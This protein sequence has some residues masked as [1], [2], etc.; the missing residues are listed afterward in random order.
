MIEQPGDDEIQEEDELPSLN[1]EGA[2]ELI[3]EAAAAH[4]A[5]KGGDAAESARVAELE[6]E[7]TASKDRLLRLQADYDNFRKRAVKQ[8]QESQDFG[9]EKFVKDLLSSVDNLE[10]ALEH[11]KSNEGAEI[12][13]GLLEGV[14][15]VYR[16]MLSVLQKHSVLVVDATGQPFNPALHEAMGQAP[17]ASVP[18]NTVIEVFQ[19]GYELK[20]HLLRPA[21]V[22]VSMAPP[23]QEDVGSADEGN[24]DDG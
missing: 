7:L 10:R 18:A 24:A 17:D 3:Q 5:R 20:N 21:R 12:L 13:T 9:H 11:A 6:E 16:E 2:D 8:R 22:I 14:E 1:I 19:K 4:E 15:L 23:A